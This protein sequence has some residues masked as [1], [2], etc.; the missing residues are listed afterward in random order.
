[1]IEINLLP[2]ELRKKEVSRKS[3]PWQKGLLAA[4]VLFVLVTLVL[5]VNLFSLKGRLG[6]LEK[7]WVDIQPQYQELTSLQSTV[8][9]QLTQEKDFMVRFVTS[10]QPLTYLMMWISEYLPEGAWLTS[11]ELERDG[12]ATSIE[13]QGLALSTSEKSSIEQ[14]EQYLQNL[15]GQMPGSKLSLTTTRQIQE[16]V[17]LTHF[18]ANFMWGNEE[19]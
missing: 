9:G 19:S 14:I 18:S 3:V 11:L 12:E 4:V 5:Y 15:K 17:E 6:E 13:I 8:E 16:G 2:I 7:R 10:E 1:M